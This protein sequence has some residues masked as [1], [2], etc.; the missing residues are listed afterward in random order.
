MYSSSRNQ[1]CLNK[2]EMKGTESGEGLRCNYE[3]AP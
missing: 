2:W 3:D 1:E